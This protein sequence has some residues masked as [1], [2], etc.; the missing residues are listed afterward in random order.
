MRHFDRQVLCR[1]DQ[2]HALLL[3]CSLL[4]PR[5]WSQVSL[6]VRFVVNNVNC[7]SLRNKADFLPGQAGVLPTK[8]PMSMIRA[9][10]AHAWPQVGLQYH[11][12]LDRVGVGNP[13]DQRHQSVLRRAPRRGDNQCCDQPVPRAPAV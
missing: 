7:L 4:Q 11:G 10:F 3:A 6:M 13:G 2:G 12:T 5:D 8:L 1:W 9:V